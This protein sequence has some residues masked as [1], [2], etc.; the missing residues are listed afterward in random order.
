MSA[1]GLPGCSCSCSTYDPLTA[2][3]C[4]QSRCPCSLEPCLSLSIYSLSLAR[5][6]FRRKLRCAFS[7]PGGTTGCHRRPMLSTPVPAIIYL[8]IAD[9]PAPYVCVKEG[10]SWLARAGMVP[11]S[12]SPGSTPYRPLSLAHTVVL[13][14]CS[15]PA[16]LLLLVHV[17]I[18][19]SHSTLPPFLLFRPA[20]R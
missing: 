5:A 18:C 19:V 12:F 8:E 17:Q 14:W 20:T 7:A 10:R 16:I 9:Q 4:I 6:L 1:Y 15:L 3:R 2:G 13:S 11:F